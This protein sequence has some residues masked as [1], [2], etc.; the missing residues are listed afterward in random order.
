LQSGA[1]V[2]F[3]AVQGLAQP[4]S[5]HSPGTHR[6]QS[7]SANNAHVPRRPI[8]HPGIMQTRADLEF[9][10]AKIG[11]GEELWKS[12]WQI[13]LNSPVASLDFT[14]KPFVHVVR[15]AYDAGDQ[16]GHEIQESASA[17][18]NHVMQWWVTGNEAHAHKA[19][20]I[21]DAWSGTLADFSETMQCYSPGGPAASS[22][23]RRRSFAQLIQTG[24][25][26]RKHSS[27]ACY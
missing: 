9:M 11:A 8:V 4:T 1:G 13:W 20:E 5:S 25:L 3:A 14:P 12:S 16:G 24:A 22:A 27:G 18:E 23:T 7:D 26:S 2:A 21:L 15:G 17:A 10:K 19:I 6:E